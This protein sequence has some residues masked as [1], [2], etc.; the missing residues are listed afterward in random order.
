MSVSFAVS[1]GQTF[2]VQVS[3][4]AFSTQLPNLA[5]FTVQVGWSGAYSWQTGTVSASAVTV[6]QPAGSSSES[7]S[8]NIATPDSTVTI[9][10]SVT[11]TGSGDRSLSVAY[12]CS[13]VSSN[14]A[15]NN[16]QYSLQ[17]PNLTSCSVSVG[18]A[19]SYSWQSGNVAAGSVGVNLSPGSH[20]ATYNVVANPPP[21]TVTVSGTISTTY[22]TSATLITFVANG[23]QFTATPTSGSYSI[24]L[25]NLATFTV[26]VNWSGYLQSGTCTPNPDTY[27]LNAAAGTTSIGGIDWSC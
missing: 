3:N 21:S 7:V 6:N 5:T 23:M 4:N 22:G 25:P 24:V 26:S 17:V 19:G 27:T 10:G 13:G 15:V 16:N 11:T 12:S 8:I 2:T 1:G 9:S 18:W 14:A 20:A